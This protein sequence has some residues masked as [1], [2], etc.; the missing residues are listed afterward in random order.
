MA[1]RRLNILLLSVFLFNG[2]LFHKD[3]NVSA[4]EMGEKAVG[5]R[6]AFGAMVGPED[7]RR[8]VAITRDTLLKSGDQLK[9]IEKTKGKILIISSQSDSA[10]E[11]ITFGGM[12]ALL[13]YA[14]T[15]D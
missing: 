1:R 12:I 10:S 7:D 14:L 8:L 6:W 13:R 9:M 4:E 11:L 5:F 15:W 3:L 2:F